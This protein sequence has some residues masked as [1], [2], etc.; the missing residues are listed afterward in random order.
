MLLRIKVAI[1]LFVIGGVIAM[2]VPKVEYVSRTEEWMEEQI[3]KEL[4]GYR[5]VQTVKM[6]DQTYKI[7]QPFGIVGRQFQGPDGR[8]YEFLVIAGNSRVSFHDPQ[9]CFSAQGWIF[10]DVWTRDVN[11]PVVG[12][13]VPATILNLERSGGKAV[14][15]YFYRTPYTLRGSGFMMPVD[16]TFAKLSGRPSVD[17]QFFRFL[18]SPSSNDLEKDIAA[19]EH[20]ADAMLKE[21]SKAP[22]GDYFVASK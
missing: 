4:P 2:F 15:M 19:L 20:F 7:L 11:V 5:F 6:N 10:K 8:Y 3:P 12:D 18:L 1:V 9:V 17:G 21:V 14:A 13:K 22:E 16:M